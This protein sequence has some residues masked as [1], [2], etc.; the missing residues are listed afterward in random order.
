MY[1]HV[2]FQGNPIALPIGK[3]ACIG[4]NY[5]DHIEEMKSV[6]SESPLLFLKPKTA[7]CDL[8]KPLVIPANQGECHNELEVAVLLKHAL[9]KATEDEVL[10]AI[11][12][13]G[14]GLDLTLRDV[15]R[16]LKAQG[17]PWERAKS[18]D[19]SSPVSGFV[20]IDST[21][22]LQDLHFTL[23]INGE[24]RQSGHTAMMLHK[25][26]PLIA[27]MSQTFTL[28]AGDV[29]LTGTPKGV[30][31]LLAGDTIEATLHDKITVN[32]KVVS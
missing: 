13:I 31:P 10:A 32:T 29:V 2:E 27:H 26:V 24:V 6:V 30:G 14:L 23:S 16:E 20:P 8:A 17:Q 15:Q 12:G 1:Q 9:C 3:V 21:T 7:L 4:R 19:L 28:D 5:L 11:W 22:D 25:I 18:F